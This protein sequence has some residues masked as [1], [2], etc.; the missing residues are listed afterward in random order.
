MSQG[1]HEAEKS[2]LFRTTCYLHYA[3]LF[4]CSGFDGL[5]VIVPR[6]KRQ[7]WRTEKEKRQISQ[8]SGIL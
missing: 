2:A 1:S 8:K 7:E 4:V 5:S 6:L 3:Y